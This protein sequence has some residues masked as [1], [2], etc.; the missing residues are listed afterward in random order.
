MD[1]DLLK[2]FLEVHRTRHFGRA[3]ESLFVTQ[4]AVSA[5]I[6]QLEENLGVSLFSRDRNNIQPTDAGRRLLAHAERIVATWQRVRQEVALPEARSALLNVGGMPSLWDTLLPPWLAAMHRTHPELLLQ[7]E[8]L[9]SEALLRRLLDGTLD[10]GLTFDPPGAPSLAVSELTRIPLQLVST[11]PGAHLSEALGDDYLLVDWGA[12]FAAEHARRF[13]ERAVPRMRLGLGRMALGLLLEVGG[14][15]YLAGPMVA[16]HLAAG[17]LHPVADAPRF[18]R[19]V[20]AVHGGL[21]GREAT[22]GAAL[23]TLA[24]ITATD[25][26]DQNI[27]L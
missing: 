4:S 3:A 6:R 15:A 24:T 21:E 14:S 18:Q 10:L 20:Y 7:A 8:A 23:A 25:G 26:D 13:G 5:R 19:A 17:A 22:L 2:T 11:H 27:S 16:P 1:I 12:S 9:G